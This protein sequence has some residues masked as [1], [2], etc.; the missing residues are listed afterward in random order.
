MPS[1]RRCRVL[2]EP[3]HSCDVMRLYLSNEQFDIFVSFSKYSVNSFGSSTVIAAYQVWP[4]PSS[5][6]LR[7][8][9]LAPV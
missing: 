2:P 4:G 7:C 1:P 6:A 8:F 3:R 9:L 5:T